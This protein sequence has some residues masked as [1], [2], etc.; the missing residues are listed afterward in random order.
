MELKRCQRSSFLSISVK[1]LSTNT[2]TFTMT[3]V[4]ISSKTI[5]WSK[6]RIL[7]IYM[8]FV[9]LYINSIMVNRLEFFL[10]TTSVLGYSPSRYYICTDTNAYNRVFDPCTWFTSCLTGCNSANYSF[11]YGEPHCNRLA[12]AYDGFSYE[13][14]IFV[15]K[16][17]LCLQSSFMHYVIHPWKH[18]CESFDTIAF[19]VHTSCYNESAYSQLCFGDQLRV[20]NTIKSLNSSL[21]NRITEFLEEFK[22]ENATCS[23]VPCLKK[24]I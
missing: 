21:G 11:S 5:H 7:D 2:I 17:F 6:C 12:K 18:L 9:D 22:N 8:Y 15:D 14:K 4:F 24:L 13:G 3:M 1:G 23:S 20:V 19:V 16:T 10:L